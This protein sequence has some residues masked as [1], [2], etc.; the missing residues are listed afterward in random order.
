MMRVFRKI[1]PF[2]RWL[3]V[4][5]F[6]IG[7]NSQHIT[8]AVN[9][10]GQ[11]GAA[12]LILN[13]IMASNSRTLADECGEYHDWVEI[14][15][16]GDSA[17][18]LTGFGLSDCYDDPLRWTFPA[19]SIMPGEYLLVWASGKDRRDPDAPLHTNFSISSQGE[20]VLLSLA[21]GTLLD[22]L[23]PV[24]LPTDVSTGRIP[25]GGM[26]WYFFDQP[27]PGQPNSTTAWSG[28]MPAP[29][30]SHPPGFYESGFELEIIPPMEGATIYYTLDGSV[31]DPAQ[32]EPH[33][34]AFKNQYPTHPGDSSG[35]LLSRSFQSQTYGGPVN[36]PANCSQE[37]PLYLINTTF[38]HGPVVP[39]Q[40]PLQ[41][42]VVRAMA[43]K[44]GYL[45]GQE[46]VATYFVQEGIGQRFSLPVVS[47]SLPDSALF[48]YSRGVYVA[49][50]AF[51]DWRAQEPDRPVWPGAPANWDDRGADAERAVQLEFFSPEGD[52]LW[53]QGLGLRIHGGWSRSTAKKSLRLYARNFYDQENEMAFPFF[54]DQA[55]LPGGQ[56]TEAF[57]RILLR[58]GGNANSMVRDATSQLLMA[59]SATGVQRVR[60]VVHF[61]NGTYW[62]IMNIRDRQDRYHLAY[63]YGLDPGNVIIINSPWQTIEDLFML[64]EGVPEDLELINAFFDY[65]L[66]HDLSD[67]AH[68]EQVEQMLDLASYLD[69]YIM[70]IYLTNTDWGEYAGGS[71]HFRFWRVREPGPGP[72]SD[73][74]WR[75]MVWDF[76]SSLNPANVNLNLV[77]PILDHNNPPSALLMQLMAN[78]DFRHRFI[79]RFADHLNSSF[80]PQ[81]A[82]AV[83]NGLYE[84]LIHEIHH[85]RDRW[86]RHPVGNIS[87]FRNFLQRRP[88]SLRAQLMNHFALPDTSMVTLKTDP[89]KGHVRINS[90]HLTEGTPGVDDPSHWSGT[91]FQQVPLEV[92]A[93]AAPGM[94]FSHW[95]GLPEGTSAKATL[96]LDGD[97]TLTAHFWDGVVHYWH[98]NALPDGMLDTVKA[99]F[100]MTGDA[101]ITYPGDGPG[102][103]D[104]VEGSTLN[105]QMG[106]EAGFGLRV[107][108]PAN[109]RELRIEAPTTGHYNLELSYAVRR[110]T[111]GS[112][113][114]AVCFS[115]DGG[116]TWVAVAQEIKVEETFGLVKLNL[117]GFEETNNNPGLMFRFRFQDEAAANDTGN[118]RFDNIVI[119]VAGLVLDTVAPPAALKQEPYQHRFKALSGQPPFHFELSEGSLPAGLELTGEGLLNGIPTE[120][121][122]FFF[123]LELHDQHHRT[124]VQD[125]ALTVFGSELLHYWH[126]NHLAPGPADTILTD[127][128]LSAPGLLHYHGSGPGFMDRTEGSDRNAWYQVPAGNGLRVRNPAWDRALHLHTPS[129]GYY[130]LE[131]SFAVQR[132]TNGARW[133]QL[134]YSTNGG[135]DWA[136]VGLPYPIT[137][138]FQPHRLDLGQLPRVEN[139]P[140]LMFRI[141]FLGSEATQEQGNNRFDNIALRGRPIPTGVSEETFH[142]YPNPVSGNVLYLVGVHDVMLL[143]LTGRVLLSIEN[144]SEITLPDL[145]PGIYLIRN[146][147]G[148]VARIVVP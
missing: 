145:S 59:H 127:H 2:F 125:Y 74:R 136:P 27:T 96:W 38:N 93:I 28:I 3:T 16:A 115:S 34:F 32:T 10:S 121:G 106:Q 18:E 111:N 94:I 109:S 81:R 90:L 83:L 76:D 116:E 47:L 25:G 134:E 120:T 77:D 130:R 88:Y 65:A 11:Q 72:F 133:Q 113:E 107:R 17:I 30:F 119:R 131:L 37:V 146:A 92:E 60:P 140:D 143:D 42:S 22:L 141:R 118:N 49:G 79:N 95:E 87:L 84:Q 26:Q 62:G 13:E 35:P 45:P 114:H 55:A 101:R 137:M 78:E 82:V 110:T 98:F 89:S 70:F 4:L 61:I 29:Q 117:G 39:H 5:F 24:V 104:R 14:F 108:N 64:E 7:K 9:G 54:P 43:V 102:Y 46:A 75:V 122:T 58:A 97:T 105:A 52:L 21:D 132:T 123:T 44:E 1:A 69:Y 103:M 100:S 124:E 53:Q 19:V 68:F 66:N 23:E 147:A 135:K 6:L 67:V 91:Y 139:N 20:E 148:K 8:A 99:D 85:D 144:A 50:Q 56:P 12:A 15:N 142:V 71:K 80:E 112:Q 57:K 36:I 63:N 128:S 73:G 138:D 33:L 31:P 41:G 126:F 40:P 86:R 51:D 48:D 129:T